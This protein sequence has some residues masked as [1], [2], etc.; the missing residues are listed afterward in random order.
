MKRMQKPNGKY[1]FVSK[2]EYKSSHG[3]SPDDLDCFHMGMIF[4][5]GYAGEKARGQEN[6]RR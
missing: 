2:Q 5:L 4:Y 1:Y 3:E 6:I